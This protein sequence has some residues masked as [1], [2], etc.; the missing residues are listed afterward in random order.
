MKPNVWR[1]VLIDAN[2]GW[3]ELAKR[4]PKLAEKLRREQREVAAKAHRDPPPSIRGMR[5]R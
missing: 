4:N 3:P 2:R 1:E 5:F